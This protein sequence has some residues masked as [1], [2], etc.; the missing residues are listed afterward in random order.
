VAAAKA[1]T[2]LNIKIHPQLIGD[3]AAR[4]RRACSDLEERWIE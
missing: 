3:I 1:A 2:N 4:K